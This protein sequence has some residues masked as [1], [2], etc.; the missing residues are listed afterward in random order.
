[1]KE[2]KIISGQLKQYSFKTTGLNDSNFIL[3]MINLCKI[4]SVL[5]H[6]SYPLKEKMKMSSISTQVP[7]QLSSSNMNFNL[8]GP[9]WVKGRGHEAEL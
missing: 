9:R 1:M 8:R 4:N 2:K 3:R 6:Y 5:S 7:I